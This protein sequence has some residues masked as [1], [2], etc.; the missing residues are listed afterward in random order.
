MSLKNWSQIMTS[1]SVTFWE[2]G[3]C[4][5]IIPNQFFVF[6]PTTQT[7]THTHPPHTLCHDTFTTITP[8]SIQVTQ[9]QLHSGLHP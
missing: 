8:K 3:K 2:V 5:S 4:V 9:L 1:I 6:Q 7:H